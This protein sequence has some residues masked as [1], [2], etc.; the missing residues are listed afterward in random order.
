M[1]KKTKKQILGEQIVNKNTI[2]KEAVVLLTATILIF[3]SIVVV[4][5]TNTQGTQDTAE[6]FNCEIIPTHTRDSTPVTTMLDQTFYAAELVNDNFEYFDPADPGTTTIFGPVTLNY[7]AGTWFDGEYYV[8]DT[9]TAGDGSIYTVDTTNGDITLVCTANQNFNGIASDGT[10]MYGVTSTALYTVDLGSGACTLVGNFDA[11]WLMIDIGIDMDTGIAWG[12]EIVNDVIYEIDLSDATTTLLGSTGWNANYAQG[13]EY[14]QDNDILYLALFDGVAFYAR[15]CTVNLGTGAATNVGDI[16]VGYYVEYCALAIPYTG[17]EPKIPDLEC[18]GE[19][20][21][22]DVEPNSTVEG[23]FTVSN[24][25]E[26]ESLLNW[27]ISEVPTWG[28]NWTFDPDGGMGLT[29]EDGAVT[30]TVT[31]QAPDEAEK[32]FEGEIVIMNSADPAD[33][34]T[35]SVSL[36]TPV[37]QSQPTLFMQFISWLFER[38]PLL[39]IIFG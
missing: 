23:T 35:I 12:H 2:C 14:D 17:T 27:E 13:M 18:D 4:A 31:V 32:E 38:F 24:G 6:P 34:C 30:V 16:G 33:S 26:P 5:N 21:W 37:S 29:P 15:L 25:G 3:S 20:A 22:T 1:I 10:T 11:T 19:L 9:G 36:V 8:Q 39:A 28:T 7:Y